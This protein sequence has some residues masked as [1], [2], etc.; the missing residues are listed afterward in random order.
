[1]REYGLLGQKI[2]FWFLNKFRFI[3]NLLQEYK[4]DIYMKPSPTHA[5]TLDIQDGIC[6][7]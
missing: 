7:N 2:A 5:N 1:M 4:I 3:E 6:W